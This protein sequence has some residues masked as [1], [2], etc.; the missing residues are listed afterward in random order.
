M[1]LYLSRI[2]FDIEEVVESAK[3]ANAHEFI[4]RLPAKYK[5]VI[6]DRGVK[7][8]GGQKQRISLARAFYHGRKI[9]VLDEATSA[10]DN[11]TE[12]EIVSE[13]KELKGN[14]T[15]IIIAHRYKTV[16]NCDRIYVLE[17]GV[18]K[19]TGRPENILKTNKK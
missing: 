4:Q 6:G 19:R 2:I 5:T 12:E 3:K 11:R 17:N 15:M 7:L 10:L 16:E 18:I 1:L 14:H 9:L 8:S 13:I